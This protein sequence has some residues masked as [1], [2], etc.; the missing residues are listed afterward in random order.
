MSVAI[1]LVGPQ[2]TDADVRPHPLTGP[3]VERLIRRLAGAPSAAER[4]R[5]VAEFWAAAERRGTPLV[6]ELDGEPGHRAVTFL[7]RGHRAT[8][9]V[10]LLGNRLADREHLAASLLRRIPD[11]DIWHLG[12][13]LRA[14]HRG[15]YQLAADVSPGE[16][17][18]DPRLLQE[19]LR[20]LS[21][22]AAPDPLNPRS[23][24]TRWSPAGASVFALSDAPAQPWAERRAGI[25]R[26]TVSRHRRPGGALDGERDVWVYLPPGVDPA[27]TA[28]RLTTTDQDATPNATTPDADSAP[29][30]ATPEAVSAP[31]AIT[32]ADANPAA[33]P[34]PVAELP[35]LVLCDGDMWFGELG[36]QDTLDALIADGAVPPLAVLA[37]DAVDNPTRWGDLGGRDTYVSFLADLVLPW[38]AA[39]WPL[40]TDPARTVI[41]GQSLGGVTALYA[42]HTRADRFGHALAQ[43]ASLWWRP[44]LPQGVPKTVSTETPWLVSL[45][46]GAERRPVSVR[47]AV[48]LHEGRMVGDARTL[49]AALD[50]LG[51]PVTRTEYNGGHDYACWRGCLADGLAA[52]LGPAG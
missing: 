9:Q 38:A 24:P 47:L 32:T 36:F 12:L 19:R 6:E 25:A 10:L 11:T 39:R 16:P 1:P 37:P 29:D 51:Y 46:T 13:K 42:V 5:I 40:T 28:D 14:D 18:A 23:L 17:P 31:D 50:S 15:S 8:R 4:D 45:F 27:A 3:A 21:R 49:H 43:S 7:W 34:D 41:A 26:G 30:A 33:D 22:Y 35:V 52:T 2:L 20:G 48:G 44:G